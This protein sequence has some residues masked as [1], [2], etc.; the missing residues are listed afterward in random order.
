M[1]NTDISLEG[2]DVAD[3]EKLRSLARLRG[4]KARSRVDSSIPRIPRDQML[5]LSLAQRRL[6]FLAQME[7][8][9]TSYHMPAAMRLKGVLDVSALRRTL[10]AILCRHEALR[11]AFVVVDDEPRVTL[12]PE[13]HPFPMLEHDLREHPDP[14]AALSELR[15]EETLTSF[16]LTRGPMIRARLIQLANADYVL[17]ITQHHIA[18]DGWSLG[19]LV[20]EFGALYTAFCQGLPDPLPPLPCNTQTMRHGNASGLP[21]TGWR[22][23]WTIGIALSPTLLPC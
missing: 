13:T 15:N 19:I 1:S 14:V 2:M 18:S 11:S 21:R 22:R 6:W 16:D 12:L 8:A 3:L 10:G 4:I 7:G 9:S 23:S 17:L 5:P 20:N